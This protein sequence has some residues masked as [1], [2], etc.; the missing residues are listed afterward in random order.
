MIILHGKQRF[1]DCF[2]R[3]LSGVQFADYVFNE[4]EFELLALECGA[5]PGGRSTTGRKAAGAQRSARRLA[6]PKAEQVPTF[7]F[8]AM[9]L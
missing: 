1:H 5:P 4:F 7:Q 6:R 2:T 9:N 3:L 8:W